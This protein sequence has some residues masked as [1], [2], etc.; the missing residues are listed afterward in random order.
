MFLSIAIFVIYSHTTDHSFISFDDRLNITGN[1]H[2]RSGLSIQNVKW[3]FTFTQKGDRHYWHPLTSISHMLDCHFFGLNPLGHHLSNIS[4]HIIN[5]LLLYILFFKMTTTRWK[6]ALIAALFALHP[7]NVE[8]VIWV[9]ERKNVL[10]TLFWFLTMLAYTG[11]AKERTI[12]RYLLVFICMLFG[13][14]CKPILV[15]LPFVLLLLDFWPL[16]RIN[17]HFLKSGTINPY[18][19]INQFVI[20]FIEKLPLF[21]L[22]TFWVY[23]SSL[24]MGRLGVIIPS[25]AVPMNLRL[26]NALVSYVKYLWKM[27]WPFNL[28]IFYPFPS[29]MLPLWQLSGAIFFIIL[30]TLTSIWVI[31]KKPWLTV[32][33]LWYLGTLFP[34]IGLVQNGLWPEMADRWTYVPLIGIFIMII[35]EIPDL[36]R[37]WST[38]KTLHIAITTCFLFLF[39]CLS[40]IQVTYWR[41]NRTLYEHAINVTTD[42]AV[43]YNNLGSAL[44]K[45]GKIDA[46]IE[47]FRKAIEIFPKF[48]QANYNLGRVL[49]AGQKKA[50]A[51]YFLKKALKID[52]MF[53]EAYNNLGAIFMMEGNLEQAAESFSKA[54]KL[55]PNLVYAHYNLGILMTKQGKTDEAFKHLSE[56]VK[57]KP[58][59][60]IA[61]NKLNLIKKSRKNLE[62]K[63]NRIKLQLI[64]N[65]KDPFLHY[66][67]GVIYKKHYRLDEALDQFQMAFSL[68]PDFIQALNNIAL[69]YFERKDYNKAIHVFHKALELQPANNVFYYNIGCLYSIQNKKNQSVEYLQKAVENGYD[70]L[71]KLRKDKDLEN[72]R[73]M[74]EYKKL[75]EKLNN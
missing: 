9:A 38:R 40:T 23:L 63:I 49:A 24:S 67:L 75:L 14:L 53:V 74:P 57:L 72:I 32:G 61:I 50:E 66:K 51:K 15:T 34:V 43:A 48:K 28:S 18:P 5:T 64:L 6:S 44:T 52:P 46:G 30:I 39:I 60:S 73:S 47:S 11:F 31:R 7:L 59:F 54:L 36:H 45:N 68:K 8:S 10:S 35:W 42:N 70:N 20:L 3:A 69:I 71:L 58:D 55:N 25:E 19:S 62:A 16:K 65:P 17:F 26:A 56:A 1:P 41:N 27:I 22:S 29:K 2:V 12:L 4:L 13:L 33:W 21:A 37:G